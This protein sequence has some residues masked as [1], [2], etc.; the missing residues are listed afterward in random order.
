MVG[1][2]VLLLSYF[3]HGL[4]GTFNQ[5][6]ERSSSSAFTT[7]Q[8]G[9]Q[10]FEDETVREDPAQLSDGVEPPQDFSHNQQRDTGS[11]SN[12]SRENGAR[13]G[14]MSQADRHQVHPSPYSP[15]LDH[16]NANQQEDLVELLHE[17][18]PPQILHENRQGQ[19]ESPSHEFREINSP[20]KEMI[21]QEYNAG[22]YSSGC[23]YIQVPLED[24]ISDSNTTVNITPSNNIPCVLLQ[25]LKRSLKANVA[26]LVSAFF[27]G[28]LGMFMLYVN[29]NTTNLCFEWSQRFGNLPSHM[30]RWSLI[31]E[32]IQAIILNLGFSLTMMVLFGWYEFKSQYMSTLLIGLLVGVGVVIYKINLFVFGVY[33]TED[34]YRYPCN[35]LF[36]MC[37]ISSS[38]LLARKIRSVRSSVATSTFNIAFIISNN[39]ITGFA[40]GM[41]YRYSVV[42]RYVSEKDEVVKVIIAALTPVVALIPTGISKYCVLRHSSA[43][44]QEDRSFLLCYYTH[45]ISIALYR[46]MQA[47]LKSFS[48][49]ILFSVIHGSLNVVAKATETY[50]LKKWTNLIKLIKKKTFRCRGLEPTPYDTPHQRRLTADLEI[51]DMLFQYTA[52]ILSQAYVVFYLMSSFDF[53]HGPLLV[54]ALKRVGL[55]LLIDYSFNCLS[56]FLQIQLHNI[57]I[58]RVW[59]KHWKRHLIANVLLVTVT[60]CYFTPVLLSVQRIRVS[61][62]EKYTI[63]NCTSPFTSW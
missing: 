54:K 19:V 46:I 35:V 55:G 47:D 2:F 21:H 44:I 13:A 26:I 31:G 22:E 5:T 27:L 16:C 29:L 1:M 6:K 8:Q 10:L 37:I 36:L 28:L 62:P 42:P 63:R 18:Q 15:Q 60:V 12:E 57:P 59:S 51:Q 34:F 17:A 52:L 50:W 30:L 20:K 33:G 38:Y 3:V 4:S 9:G 43:V 45:G 56:V 48:L 39:F 61:S 32:I 49:F 40:C 25:S 58:R 7:S 53:S 24:I 41:A 11:N 23:Y 14:E